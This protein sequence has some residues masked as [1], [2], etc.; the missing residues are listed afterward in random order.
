MRKAKFSLLNQPSMIFL[1]S[2]H[3]LKPQI[4]KRLFL[5]AFFSL[6]ASVSFAQLNVQLHYDF[7]NNFYGDELSN[8]PK[9]TATIENFTPDKWGSTYFF[10]DA[11]LANNSMES[12]YAEF[13]RELKFWDAPVALHLEYNGGLSGGGS[14]NDAYL[15]GGAYNWASSDFSKTFSVQAMYKYLA[16]QKIGSHH[17]WQLT[18]VWGVHFAN[19]LYS[20]TGFADLWHDNS[21]AGN[22]V[23]CSEP[24]FWVNFKA[25]EKVDDDFNLSL[26]VELELSN[27]LV[28]PTNGMNN[29]F[30]F[31][32]T[33]AAK[34]VF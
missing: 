15:F 1:I 19:G 16:K 21:V 17:S 7:G 28:W 30:Y 11:N 6:L 34:W 4:M 13:S 5:I 3:S 26:G 29:E 32:P 22:L 8:R 14:Y 24:Q 9:L 18:T 12:V 33:I 20:F 10:V 27:C 25:M 31:I 2:L 23:F